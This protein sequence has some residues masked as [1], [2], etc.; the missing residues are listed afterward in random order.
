MKTNPAFEDAQLNKT[1]SDNVSCLAT[2]EIPDGAAKP[3]RISQTLYYGN[4]IQNKSHTF[5]YA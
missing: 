3:K 5:E 4:E 1:M 2:S